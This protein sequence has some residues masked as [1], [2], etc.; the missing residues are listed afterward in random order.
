MEQKPKGETYL[1]QI[2]YHPKWDRFIFRYLDTTTEAKAMKS[3]VIASL[4]IT[5]PSLSLAGTCQE[6]RDSITRDINS[7]EE[8]HNFICGNSDCSRDDI[9]ERI[10]IDER[11]LG[12][13][14]SGC[15]VTPTKKAEN[16]YTSLYLI[17]NNKLQPQ[18]TFFGSFLCR[19][20]KI[21]NNHYVIYGEERTDAGSKERYAFSWKDNNYISTSTRA[22]S[23]KSLKC[24]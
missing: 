12:E 11:K 22:L 18:F 15:F 1:Q 20:K 17:I 3:L 19:T 6:N 23:A 24:W 4:L 16:Y 13:N 21:I 5:T 2:N 7:D 14:I 10:D 9:L 8:L